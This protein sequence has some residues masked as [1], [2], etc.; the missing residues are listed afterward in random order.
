LAEFPAQSGTSLRFTYY[1]AN[2]TLLPAPLDGQALGA[3]PAFGVTAQR[4]AVRRVLIT[5]TAQRDVPG[6]EPQ[7]YMLTSDVKLR[8]LLP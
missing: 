1:D 5:L 6:H 4:A 7:T 8:N 2:G 3:V